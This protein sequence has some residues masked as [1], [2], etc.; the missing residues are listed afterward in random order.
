MN[1]EGLINL[2]KLPIQLQQ[3]QQDKNSPKNEPEHSFWSLKEL[4]TK[5]N[6][7]ICPWKRENGTLI[8]DVQCPTEDLIIMAISSFKN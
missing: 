1:A 4:K 6:L 5:G 8:D 7:V 2:K 3:L